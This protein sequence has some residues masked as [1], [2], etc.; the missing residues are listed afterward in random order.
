MGD[1][2]VYLS[3]IPMIKEQIKRIPRPFP[4]LEIV[5]KVENIDDFVTSDFKL[6]NYKPHAKIEMPMAV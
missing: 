1:S 4:E 2:H 3:H 5:R 6:V